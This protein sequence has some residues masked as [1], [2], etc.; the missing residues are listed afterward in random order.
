MNIQAAAIHGLFLALSV[1]GPHVSLVGAHFPH[2]YMSATDEKCGRERS[3]SKSMILHH[4]VRVCYCVCCLA[5]FVLQHHDVILI[6]ERAGRRMEDG[7]STVPYF[8]NTIRQKLIPVLGLREMIDRLDPAS[9]HV[10][11]SKQR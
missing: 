4:R 8:L 9:S 3:A 2:D 6:N 5:A 11:R 7:I 10:D 1:S